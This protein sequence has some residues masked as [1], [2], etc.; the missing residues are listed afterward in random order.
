MKEK[1]S[2]SEKTHHK[3]YRM[4]FAKILLFCLIPII[5]ITLYL[6]IYK[7][8]Q[9]KTN[10]ISES[11]IIT[12]TSTEENIYMERN[13]RVSET[14]GCDAERIGIYSQD[15]TRCVVL[16]RYT[17]LYTNIKYSIENDVMLKNST[18]DFI[19]KNL[20]NDILNNISNF[21]RVRQSIKIVING[22]E[23]NNILWNIYTR[24][25]KNNWNI[26]NEDM[27][28]PKNNYSEYIDSYNGIKNFSN[29]LKDLS[30]YCVDTRRLSHLV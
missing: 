11:S 13:L 9:K 20:S 27:K 16:E 6:L 19:A 22:G 17:L 8:N 29:I 14:N 12:K 10:I 15:T 4:S 18:I 25:L 5:S 3:I 23:M 2:L 30:E 26:I 24:F 28:C 1:F 21:T 7:F